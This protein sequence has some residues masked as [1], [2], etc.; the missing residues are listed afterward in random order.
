MSKS[1]ALT[2][3]GKRVAAG[4]FGG[5]SPLLKYLASNGPSTVA[6]ISDGLNASPKRVR[7]VAT[8]L[9]R[10]GYLTVERE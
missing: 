4:S 9:V 6:D 10:K 3:K 2:D 8:G 7:S 1:L 5:G